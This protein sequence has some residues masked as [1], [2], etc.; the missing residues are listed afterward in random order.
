MHQDNARLTFVLLIFLCVSSCAPPPQSR[1]VLSPDR[2]RYHRL[3][4][5]IERI[6]SREF[7]P[8]QEE[9]IYPFTY[10]FRKAKDAEI[11]RQGEGFVL[12]HG[13]LY[14]LVQR[15]RDKTT[16][17]PGQ[18]MLIFDRSKR[19]FEAEVR[20][21]PEGN[22]RQRWNNWTCISFPDPG[23]NTPDLFQCEYYYPEGTERVTHTAETWPFYQAFS[24]DENGM[25]EKIWR[26]GDSFVLYRYNG[27]KIVRVEFG[28][29]EIIS[30]FAD[31]TYATE[32]IK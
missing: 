22:Q 7:L 25:L 4:A 29:G 14:C 30:T 10:V 26:F 5:L 27:F 31:F 12:L 13:T 9:I 19:S 20:Q 2:V 23:K 11:I 16:G 3:Q 28:R 17:N 18:R 21:W 15:W 6:G 8:A 24:W 32:S 1:T